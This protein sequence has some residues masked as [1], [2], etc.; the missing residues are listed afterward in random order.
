MDIRS[1]GKNYEEFVQRAQEEDGVIYLRGRV[2]KVYR[3]GDKIVV[4]GT[5]TLSATNVEIRADLVVLA[6]A[7]RPS[8]D[9]S[10]LANI[11]HLCPDENG[12]LT[13]AHPKLKPVETMARG[14]YIA[15]VAQAPK[16]IPDTVAQA[17]G[18]A[19]YVLNLFSSKE[20]EHDPITAGVDDDLCSGCGVCVDLCPYLARELNLKE[21]KAEVNEILCEGCGSCSAA[22][23]TGSAM[24]K[25]FTSRQILEMIKAILK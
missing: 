2:A 23:P 10:K 9:I 21:K 7:V 11:L 18:A 1:G 13:E 25:N 20:L 4:C 12:F 22:C 3:D 17:S 5:D 14:I 8:H 15:G 24:Q 16:D 6:M 19:S